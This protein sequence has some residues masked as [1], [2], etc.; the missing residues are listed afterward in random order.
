MSCTI[1]PSRVMAA[2][3]QPG[4]VEH[5]IRLYDRQADWREVARMSSMA[6]MSTAWRSP[7]T[8]VWRPRAGMAMSASMTSS[9]RGQKYK[10]DQG[11]QLALRSIPWMARSRSGSMRRHASRCSMVPRSLR[12]RFPRSAGS[13]TGR[14]QSRLVARRHD[15]VCRPANTT[16]GPARAPSWPGR[17]VGGARGGC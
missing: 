10:T 16:M 3:W 5:G 14:V 7:Q 12:Y 4:L 13:T 1:S 2:I 8:A 15:P 17:S 11:T 6:V 9:L